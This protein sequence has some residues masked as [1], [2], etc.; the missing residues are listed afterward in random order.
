MRRPDRRRKDL[1]D[2]AWFRYSEGNIPAFPDIRFTS[3]D[4]IAEGDFVAYRDTWTGTH[5]ADFMG[6]A[7]TG[8]RFSIS[9]IG[10]YRIEGGKIAEDRVAED[11]MGMM[12]QLG[13]VSQ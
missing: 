11:L 7:P 8:K 9:G 13:A 4:L 12:Q 6:L 10:A 5:Q 3:S 1:K 2:A